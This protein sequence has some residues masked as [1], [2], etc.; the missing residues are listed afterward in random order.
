MLE[1]YVCVTMHHQYNDV[2]SQQDAKSFSFIKL[3]KSALHFSGNKSAH[4][5]E[6]FFNYI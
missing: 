5:Q 6:H 4:H 3:L 1:G 2:S